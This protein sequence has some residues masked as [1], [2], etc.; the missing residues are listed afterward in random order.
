MET[1]FKKNIVDI[2][3]EFFISQ[4][5][6]VNSKIEDAANNFG[7]FLCKDIKVNFNSKLIQ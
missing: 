7:E 5:T 1:N 4:S 2:E 6:S 3:V